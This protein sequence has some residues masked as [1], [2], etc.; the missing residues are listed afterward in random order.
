VLSDRE[1]AGVRASFHVA[2]GR[3]VEARAQIAESRRGG[4]EALGYE[5]EAWLLSRE[6]KENEANVALGKAESPSPDTLA[7][8]EKRL[9]RA[10]ALN[11]RHALSWAFLANVLSAGKEPARAIEPAKRALGLAP[12]DTQVR[13]SMARALWANGQRT[14]AMGHARAAQTVAQGDDERRMA[15]DVVE[16]FERATASSPN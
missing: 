11:S 4:D 14:D 16:F 9:Q 13:L 8:A 2:T 15:R 7:T 1:A 6:G 5:A 3:A 10:V 12:S